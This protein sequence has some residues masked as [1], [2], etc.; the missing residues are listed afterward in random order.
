[1]ECFDISG[2]GGYVFECSPQSGLRISASGVGVDFATF[3]QHAKVASAQLGFVGPSFDAVPFFYGPQS[4]TGHLAGQQPQRSQQPQQTYKYHCPP[5][6]HASEA[7]LPE[8]T[9]EKPD[10]TASDLAMNDVLQVCHEERPIEVPETN[11]TDEINEI[12][13]QML[14]PHDMVYGQSDKVSG[15]EPISAVTVDG[16]EKFTHEFPYNAC[17]DVPASELPRPPEREYECESTIAGLEGSAGIDMA[18]PHGP[19]K[20]LLEDEYA[21]THGPL[22]AAQPSPAVQTAHEAVPGW[23]PA[24][25]IAPVKPKPSFVNEPPQDVPAVVTNSKKKKKKEKQ[26]TKGKHSQKEVMTCSDEDDIFLEDFQRRVRA[27]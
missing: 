6:G 25:T 9:L 23:Q 8:K 24:P 4:G 11:E 18:L 5:N 22:C 20:E 15:E 21:Q 17:L 1:M 7:G 26:Q 3:V 19:M 2:D 27:M 14:Q 10:G 13:E 12:D 16:T